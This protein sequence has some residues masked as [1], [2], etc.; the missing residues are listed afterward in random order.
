[1]SAP[2]ELPLPAPE[3]QPEHLRIAEALLFAAAEPVTPK[4]LA[5]VLPEGADVRATVAALQAALAGRGV[6]IAEVAGGWQLRTAADLAPIL[7]R[8][9]EVPRRLSR[10]A[11]ETLAIIAYHQPVTRAEIEDIRGV[12]L[13]QG[14]LDAL[15]E[16]GFVEPKGRR[17]TPGRPTTWGTTRQFLAHFGLASLK[18]LPKLEELKAAGLLDLR[19]GTLPPAGG[20]EEGAPSPEAEEAPPPP[21]DPED[22]ARD[23]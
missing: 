8:R 19:P 10:A 1:M 16:A 5:E 3:V 21:L 11:V 23:R 12:A 7:R 22:G 15:T 18:D 6:E 14:T 9:F 17:E 20:G 4:A 13:A 2:A